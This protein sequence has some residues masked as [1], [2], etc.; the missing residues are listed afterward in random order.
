MSLVEKE[1][2]VKI[3]FFEEL[4]GTASSDPEIHEE[5][6]A[7]KAPDALSVEEEVA[8]VGVDEVVEKS[9]TVFPKDENG[10]PFMWDY[11]WKGY[12]KDATK[13]LRKV[14]KSESSKITAYKQVIDKMIF[15]QPRKIGIHIPEGKEI[16]SCQRPLRG[17]TAR[18]EVIA[19]A[20]S[21]TVPE[22]SYVEF[23]IGLLDKKHE[24]WV[25]ELLEYGALGGTGQWRNSGKGRFT[26]EYLD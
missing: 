24:K 19:L 12:F 17:Q 11:Q 26:V 14:A 25:K 1:L 8:A 21:E 20:N 13:A 10:V 3:T 22:G 16:G 7:S 4:L 2:K 23:S 9:K 6:I 18:G 15:P 5:F